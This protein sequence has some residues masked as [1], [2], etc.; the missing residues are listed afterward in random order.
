MSKS[1]LGDV[2]ACEVGASGIGR[3][4]GGRRQPE[5]ERTYNQARR[6]ALQAVKYIDRIP[7]NP[8]RQVLCD[9]AYHTIDRGFLS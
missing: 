7:S 6:R 5:G 8:Y 4:K 2:I 3:P 1:W 9:F